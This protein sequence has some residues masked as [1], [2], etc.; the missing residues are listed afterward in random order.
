MTD[1]N[2]DG[3]TYRRAAADPKRGMT[4]DELRRFV[5][6]TGHGPDI[7]GTARVHVITTW[8]GTIRRL[9]IHT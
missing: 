1:K 4:L 7:P 3:Y 6:G 2:L 9:E 8:R 5:D